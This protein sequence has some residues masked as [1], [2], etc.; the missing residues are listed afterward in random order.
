MKKFVDDIRLV[1]KCCSLYYEDDWKQQEIADYLSV[2]RASVSR[3]LQLGKEMGMVKVE[4]CNPGVL[5]Y[6]QL[7]RELERR[8]GLK[9]VIIAEDHP[10]NT[11]E[12]KARCL[13]EKAMAY[14][15][16]VLKDGEYVGVSMGHTLQ[17]ITQASDILDHPVNCTFV[18]IVGG[19][20]RGPMDVQIHSNHIA[21]RFAE[22]FGG[23]SL[24]FFAPAV[25]SDVT[26]LQGFLNE[27]PIRNFFSYYDKLSTVL[28]GIGMPSVIGSTMVLTEYITEEE[29]ELMVQEGAVGDIFLHFF[30]K[31]GNMEPFHH[32]N[33]RIA[34]IDLERLLKI[35]RRVGIAMGTV[36]ATSVLGAVI[37]K[38]VNVLVIDASCA[39]RVIEILD[40]R[41]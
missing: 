28:M 34:S 16:H 23:N 6:D 7:E 40:E 41:G 21:M 30:D 25:F 12:E 4:V 22:I 18:P 24:Q 29:M 39:Q 9:E 14:L 10:F 38:L 11:E 2:S 3:M 20:S 26:V 33:D 32:I 19:I 13:G 1:Y 35:D 31:N 15:S 17:K 8:L 5:T 36:K 27:M 37:G